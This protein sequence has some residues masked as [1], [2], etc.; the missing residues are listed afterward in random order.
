MDS[1]KDNNDIKIM[2]TVLG[3][4]R[5]TYYTKS[6]RENE[7]IKRIYIERIKVYIVYLKFII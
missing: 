1:N 2:C 7:A 3:V 6:V 4:S 5:S